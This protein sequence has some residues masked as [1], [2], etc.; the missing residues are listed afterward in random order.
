M[1]DTPE[2]FKNPYHARKIKCC[3]V[4]LILIEATAACIMLTMYY[5]KDPKALSDL[6]ENNGNCSLPLVD[7]NDLGNLTQ[8]D[9]QAPAKEYC[10]ISN[11]QSLLLPFGILA[12]VA[13]LITI[14]GNY[15]V[16]CSH[17]YAAKC[18]GIRL[19]EKRYEIPLTSE[20]H[21]IAVDIE[22]DSQHSLKSVAG[23]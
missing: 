20:P 12:A 22:R 5:L 21:G 9:C 2:V 18:C 8:T 3:I 14:V 7:C 13:T 11:D 15:C 17:K 23:Q 6:Q 10:D 1:S 4:L 16:A 19:M